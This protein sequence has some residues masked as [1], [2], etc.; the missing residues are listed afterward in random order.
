MTEISQSNAKQSSGSRAKLYPDDEQT[1]VVFASSAEEQFYE[2]CR[3]TLGAGWQVYHS[4]TLST[5]DGDEGLKD[6]EIDFVCYH[7]E[8]GIVVVEVKGGRIRHDGQTGVF[9]SVNRRGESFS[10]KDPFQ[11][12]LVWKGRFLR[13]LRR[14]NVKVPVSHAVC[15]PGAS[16]SEFPQSSS[17]VPEIIIGRERIKDLGRS[18]AEIASKSQPEHYRRFADVGADLDRLLIGA[19][20]TTKLYLRDYIDGHENQLRDVENI[21][22]TL[23]MP[24]ASVNRLGIEGEAGTGKTMLASML[25]KHFRDQGKKVL[26]L[27]SNGLLNL[28]LKRDLGEGIVAMT[29]TDIG[30]NHGINLLM[31][32]SEY[33]GAREDWVQYE[34]PERLKKAIA[35]STERYD[36]L[37]CDEAQDVQPFWWE[38]IETLLVQNDDARF[39]LFFDSSQGVFGSGSDEQAFVATDTLPIKPPYFP[40]VHNYRTTREIAAFSRSFRR[41][42][43]MMHSHSGRLGY[44]PEIVVYKDAEDARRLLGKL[45]RQLTREEGLQNS[46]LTILSA[47]NPAAKESVLYQTEEVIKIPLHRLTHTQKKS[48]KEAKAPKSSIGISTIAGFKGLE[49]SVGILMNVSEYNLPV[50]HPIMASLIYVACTRAKHML[51][52][53]VR[54]NDPKRDAFV[55]ALSAIKTTGSMVVDGGSH[56]DFEFIGRVTHYNP[57]RVGWLSVEDPAFEQGSVMFFPSDVAK[58]NLKQLQVGTKVKFRPRAEGGITIACDLSVPSLMH[59]GA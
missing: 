26:V 40:L 54:E 49:T 7:P 13:F 31:P 25:A 19:A 46:D 39:Y 48:W 2:Q 58:A 15:F 27:G 5:M 21:H 10:I 14:H 23:I 34:A 20:F 22:T 1:R 29:Y 38:A 56:G 9:Y 17:I 16:E 37:I 30:T 36:V 11:Q 50:D 44:V 6:N 8:Y 4:C 24:I 59:L 51:Y 12:S 33:T 32:A 42:S 52:I 53:F 18:L 35:A 41:N 55:K 45:V 57:E 47:R 3:A 43:G 28:L